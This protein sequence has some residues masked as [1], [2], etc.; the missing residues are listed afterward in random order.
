MKVL[1]KNKI[2]TLENDEMICIKKFIRL[3][4]SKLPLNHSISII[5][6]NN[7]T[8][9]MT[10]GVRKPNNEIKV[11]FKDRLLIDILRT[12]SHEWVHEYQHQKLNL[13]NKKKIQDIGG[14]EENMANT[15]SGIL[16]KL[17]AKKH[18]ETEN[19]LYNE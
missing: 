4:Q 10:T 7:R 3:L 6:T 11:L 13:D 16:V 1:I 2:N 19:L 17:F 5:F 12:L 18:P 9:V 15:L 8:G 14:P